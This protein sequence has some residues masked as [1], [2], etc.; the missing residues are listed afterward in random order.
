[1]LR[2]V[3]NIFKILS[4]YNLKDIKISVN[5]WIKL[6]EILGK[7]NTG[8]EGRIHKNEYK[9]RIKIQSRGIMVKLL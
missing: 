1:M 5:I 8:I 4:F 3:W 2:N 6:G 9:S 7:T